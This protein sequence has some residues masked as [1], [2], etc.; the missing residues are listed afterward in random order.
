LKYGRLFR[1]KASYPPHHS[2]V[3]FAILQRR[4]RGLPP[5]FFTGS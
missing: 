5:A 2:P 4:N 1:V 3:L